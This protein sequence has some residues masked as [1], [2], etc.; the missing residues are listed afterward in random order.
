MSFSPLVKANDD[1]IPE[2]YYSEIDLNGLYVYN[3]TAFGDESNWLDYSDFSLLGYFLSN[4]GGQIHLNI[5]GFYNDTYA[6]YSPFVFPIPFMNITIFN[7]T[8]SGLNENFQVENR[9]QNE[10]ANNL[11]LGYYGYFTPGFLAPTNFS[12]LNETAQF[13]A[14]QGGTALK[15]EETYN[16]I[17]FDFNESSDTYY[18]QQTELTYE[19]KTGLLVYAKT[20]HILGY[21][22]E[23][24]SMNYS[25]NYNTTYDYDVIDFGGDVEWYNFLGV[26]EGTFGTN[27]TGI[28]QVNFTGNYNKD[29]FDWGNVFDDPIPWMNFS[30]F[31][32]NSGILS[33]NF[34]LYNRSNSEIAR[35]LTLGYND[36]QSG[37]LIPIQNLSLVKELAIQQKDGYFKGN[38]SILETALTIKI[39]YEQY[40]TGQKTHL[41]YE[42]FTGLLL[43]GNTSV[44]NY[45]LELLIHGYIPWEEEL[46]STQDYIPSNDNPIIYL[47]YLI[48]VLT[49]LAVGIP[50]ELI[51]K[52]N[53]KSKK[54][55]LITIIGICSFSGL[56]FLNNNMDALISGTDTNNLKEKVVDIT[57]IV[58][59][60]NGT[61]LTWENFTLDNFK[62]T[63]YDALNKWCDVELETTS[64]GY[65]V[66][67]ID[68]ISLSWVYDMTDKNGNP[69][70]GL[71]VTKEI[72]DD[73]YSIYFH[74][75]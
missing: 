11:F 57:L 12:W 40:P 74:N 18:Q 49:S 27:P 73:G 62:I 7:K 1:T 14:L 54:Y 25:L 9:S 6:G 15:V 51:P 70:Y 34:T 46:Q 17:H 32:N 35:G 38:V 55:I 75:I 45:L 3:V 64:L 71:D 16:F 8:D 13:A 68:G 52:F 72:L 60:D 63:V 28:I 21:S 30:I 22:L 47:P 31:K 42:K 44:G 48:V 67:T 24:I 29:I 2:N 61:I 20:S 36:F 53:A 58:D 66:K 59:Y 23:I 5:N 43:W 37:F 4:P 56:L 26:S 41:I 69:I 33:N 19:K 65:I 39:K 50:L 10:I